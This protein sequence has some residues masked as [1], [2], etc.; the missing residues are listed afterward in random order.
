MQRHGAAVILYQEDEMLLVRHSEE[1]RNITGFYTLPAGGT[2]PCD[3]DSEDIIVREVKEETGLDINKQYLR[4]LGHYDFT[5]ERKVGK[6]QISLDL[7]A[8]RTF[9]GKLMSG[10]ETEPIW[11]K[12][13]DFISGKYPLPHTSG[14]FLD[15]INKFLR[16]IIKK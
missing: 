8:C 13:E 10:V 11:V 12:I 14:N 4:A 2:E 7:Y 1:S 6:E 16:K 9:S 5:L 15:E 3:K